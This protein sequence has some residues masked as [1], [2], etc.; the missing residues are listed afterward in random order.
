MYV[1]R[2]N[3]LS[4]YEVKLVSHRNDSVPGGDASP[5]EAQQDEGI[6]ELVSRVLGQSVQWG[7]IN[8]PRLGFNLLQFVFHW[9]SP[10]TVSWSCRVECVIRLVFVVC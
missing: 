10:V 1:A 2:R 4:A 6:L 8:R 7:S 5:D 9:E 3:R